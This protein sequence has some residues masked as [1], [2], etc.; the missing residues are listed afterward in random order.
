MA[1]LTF[2]EYVTRLTEMWPTMI[3][4]AAGHEVTWE[5]S[6]IDR[7]RGAIRDD[8]GTGQDGG[9]GGF[10]A[11]SSMPINEAALDL[12]NLISAQIEHVASVVGLTVF[13]NAEHMLQEWA[14]LTNET[15]EYVVGQPQTSWTG[16]VFMEL[17][18]T[19]ALELVR[20]WHDRIERFFDPPKTQPVQLPCPQCGER[21]VHQIVDGQVI[22]KDALHITKNRDTGAVLGAECHR[23]EFHWERSELVLLADQLGTFPVPQAEDHAR[24]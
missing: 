12:M 23:C 15:T 7:L 16:T 10:G 24:A 2:S 13:T 11:K 21:Y 5:G 22:R 1:E 19:T 8:F 9:G 6:M 3:E 20:A 17:R 18:E 14:K 4:T